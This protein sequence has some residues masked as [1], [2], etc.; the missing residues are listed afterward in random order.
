MRAAQPG[1]V[2]AE[3]ESI[4]ARLAR[5][6]GTVDA[7]SGN[8]EAR[9]EFAG[10]VREILEELGGT[11]A[12][13]E[14][15]LEE[16]ER[17]REL[18]SELR[19][20]RSVPA[21]SAGAGFTGMETFNDR[22]P[23]VGLANPLAPPAVL[24]H[25]PE[26]NCVRG[27]VEFG[28]AFEGGPGLVHGGFL[29]ALLDEVLGVATIFSG[30]PGMTG[31]YTVRFVRPTHIKVPLH[32]EARFDGREGRKLFVSA[33]LWEGDTLT[34]K[35]TGTFISVDAAHFANFEAERTDRIGE[36]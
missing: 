14:C 29:A 26:D 3:E 4:S 15:F 11:A 33:D 21:E 22:S 35:A 30:N 25:H 28:K 19:R 1:A 32:F 7:E 2:V 24:E 12:P 18:A 31:E 34:V 17:L 16:T 20:H 36:R 23:I 10:A 13:P 6:R 5:F 8:A 27:K 9:R